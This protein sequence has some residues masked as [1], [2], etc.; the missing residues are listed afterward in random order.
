V[1]RWL[2][3]AAIAALFALNGYMPYSALGRRGNERAV[4]AHVAAALQLVGQPLPALELE[5]GAGRAVRLGDLLGRPILLVFERS[6]D[7]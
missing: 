7:W 5:D 2:A 1:T 6:V 3:T 4:R